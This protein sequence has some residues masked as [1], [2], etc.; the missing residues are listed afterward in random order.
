MVQLPTLVVQVSEIELSSSK[1]A[2]ESFQRTGFR[3]SEAGFSIAR[4]RPVCR[5]KLGGYV[6]IL[7]S[8][9]VSDTS[10]LLFTVST[11]SKYSNH[12]PMQNIS[13]FVCVTTLKI[14]LVSSLLKRSASLQARFSAEVHPTSILMIPVCREITSPYLVSSSWTWS[15]QLYPHTYVAPCRQ[16]AERQSRTVFRGLRSRRGRGCLGL[17]ETNETGSS[18]R[19][20]ANFVHG[21]TYSRS[22]FVLKLP[23]AARSRCLDR[24]PRTMRH[25]LRY[26]RIT[27][28]PRHHY[29]LRLGPHQRVASGRYFSPQWMCC[30]GR[31]MGCMGTCPTGVTSKGGSTFASKHSR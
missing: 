21:Q 17:C 12:Q 29:F 23:P 13:S 6:S 28:R 3:S 18:K 16:P 10:E 11:C 27:S 25:C 15:R 8:A 19:F 31:G 30:T 4:I 22:P 9:L 24:V 1:Q 5:M 26:V 7:D 20:Y 2:T 14:F